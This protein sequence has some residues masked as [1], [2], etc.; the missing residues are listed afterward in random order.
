[1]AEF[2]CKVGTPGGDILQQSYIAESEDALRVDFEERE[3]YVYSI[4]QRG[5]LDYLL[6]FK[7]FRSR[8]SAKEFLIFNQELAAL[9]TAG[10]PIITSL[11][12]LTERRSNPAFRRALVEIRDRVQ[13]GS[14]LSEAFEAQG[15]L[16]PKIFASSLAS[17][18]RSGE[19]AS[20]LRRYVAY[21][22]TT[23]ALRKK[24]VSALIYPVVLGVFAGGLVALLVTYII[25]KFRE[26]YSDF[27]SELP[28]I[29]RIVVGLSGAITDNLLL[30]IVAV[31]ASAA[32]F[33]AWS[34]T[35]GGSFAID[36]WKLKIPILGGIWHKYAL[37]RFSRTLSTLIAGGIPLVTSVDISAKAI[38][39]L[40]LERQV[41]DAAQKVREGGALWEA[42][43]ETDLMTDL[44]TQMMKVGES[45]GSLEEMLAN[46]AD[47]YD[48]EI[49]SNL[50]TLVSLMEPAML[51][52]MALIIAVM[53]MAIYMPLIKSYSA[54]QF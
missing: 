27:G 16:F 39:N 35:D 5:G 23:L 47:F 45:T 4:R 42:L 26:F 40:L 31:L 25:P 34:R 18:E 15:T 50:T 21:T 22:K 24:V 46:V 32:G 37:T 6:D 54:T 3:Y 49:D 33:I 12:V 48:E 51:I 11:E 52:F 20:V 1:V 53:L 30:I 19:I 28:L 17:G 38:G 7:S 44:A 8:V 9:V 41:L 14:S 2:I 29:T 13:A 36:R 43:E 10:M